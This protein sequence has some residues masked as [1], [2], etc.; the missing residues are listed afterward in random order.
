MT[1]PDAQHEIVHHPDGAMTR[2]SYLDASE[3]AVTR[4]MRDI[5]EEHWQR[6]TIGPWLLGAVFELPFEKAPNVRIHNGYLTID[7]GPWHCHLCIGAYKGKEN[8]ESLT[9]RRVA[10]IAFYD[11][12]GNDGSIK[13]R[14]SG[15]RLWNG[16][17]EQM[18]TIFFP[19][20]LLG[21]TPHTALR[22]PNWENLRLYYQFRERYLGEP[23]PEDLEQ[24]GTAPLAP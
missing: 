21:D 13:Q 3:E 10:K 17:G 4:L 15:I 19:H 2:Y 9:L 18:T 1:Q 6:I 12:R 16:Y 8:E 11:W 23:V 22:Q 7:P 14:S 20:V 24:A 5:F